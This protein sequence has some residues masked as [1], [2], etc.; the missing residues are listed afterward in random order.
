M[1]SG[2]VR[3]IAGRMRKPSASRL[4]DVNGLGEEYGPSRAFWREVVAKR[5]LP[6]IRPS[7]FRRVLVRRTDV[8]ALLASWQ[9]EA[10]AE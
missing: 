7:Q 10:G 4:L 2:G 3:A 6:V 1:G 9:D 8:E 5:L